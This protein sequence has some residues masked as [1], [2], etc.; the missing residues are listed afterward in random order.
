MFF[1]HWRQY[2]HVYAKRCQNKNPD[3]IPMDTTKEAQFL[4]K[5]K[6]QKDL[7]EA[8]SEQEKHRR[9]FQSEEQDEPMLRTAFEE[10][11]IVKIYEEDK[12]FTY[13]QA[14]E[15]AE[16]KALR[17]PTL[18]ELKKS[19]IKEGDKMNMWAFVQRADNKPDVVQLGKGHKTVKRRYFSHLDTFGPAMW[20]NNIEPKKFRP[21]HFIYAVRCPVKNTKFVLN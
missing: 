11:N 6:Y 9:E 5:Y 8:F 20:L 1:G 19:C 14:K 15:L 2:D 17:L 3:Y 16:K 4:A 10:H 13:E 21:I 7:E 18:E 12:C